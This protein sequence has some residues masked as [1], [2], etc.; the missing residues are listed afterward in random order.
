[1]STNVLVK[2]RS[3]VLVLSLT[4][5]G[6]GTMLASGGCDAFVDSFMTGL[7]IGYQMTAG[8][9]LFGSSG[10]DLGSCGTCSGDDW[11]DLGDDWDD[12]GDDF[13]SW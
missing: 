3:A 5:G 13:L 6:G 2:I 4:L 7:D 1:M 11:D 8:E 10:D 9:P 12:F